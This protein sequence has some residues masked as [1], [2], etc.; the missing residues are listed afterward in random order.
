MSLNKIKIFFS[1][2]IIYWTF[3]L[4]LVLNIYIWYLIYKF[5]DFGREFHVIHYNSYFGIDLLASPLTLLN[6]PFIGI[7]ILVLNLVLAYV[8]YFFK[9]EFKILSYFLVL[10]SFFINLELIIYLL[11][12]IAMEY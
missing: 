9:T 12:V 5:I 4:T 1:Q 3:L 10:A 6:V 7:I 2:K 8:F 11:G